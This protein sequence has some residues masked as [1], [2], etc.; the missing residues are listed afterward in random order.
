MRAWKGLFIFVLAVGLVGLFACKGG[1]YSDAK[2][3]L[4]KSIK[5]MESFTAAMDKAG[6]PKAV[7]KA[8]NEFSGDM[9]DLKPKMLALDKKYPELK[10]QA[11]PPKEL[12]PL[13]DKM[14]EVSGKLMG[15]MMKLYQYQQ[16]PDVQK[17]SE[18][19]NKIMSENE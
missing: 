4:N 1:K 11:N 12:K 8:I 5:T 7:V 14:Q 15:A 10:D 19:M 18:A 17:A 9:A 2:D 13:I 3:V 16:D 6:D